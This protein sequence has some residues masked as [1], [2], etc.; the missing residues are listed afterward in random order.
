MAETPEQAINK[1]VD[2]ETFLNFIQALSEDWEAETKIEKE[3][4]S[5]P[6][7]PGALGW[8]NGTIGGFLEAAAAYGQDHMGRGKSPSETNTW[9]AAAAMLLAGKYYE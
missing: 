5:S 3:K 2:Q 6:F 9:R 1:V 7:G 8:E 4:A